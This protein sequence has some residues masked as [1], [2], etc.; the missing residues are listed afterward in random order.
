MRASMSMFSLQAP[1]GVA[2]SCQMR[3]RR[4]SFGLSGALVRKATGDERGFRC[5]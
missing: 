1:Y 3:L 2:N 4:R 5:L